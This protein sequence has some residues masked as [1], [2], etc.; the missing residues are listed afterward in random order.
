MEKDKHKTI[1][2]FRR[3]RSKPYEVI[4]FFPEIPD[5]IN[6]LYCMSYMH[7]GQHGGAD[8]IGLLGITKPASLDDTDVKELKEE[9]EQNYGYNFTVKIQATRKMHKTCRDSARR[10]GR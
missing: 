1:V 3:W 7:V 6:G 10:I 9:L 4:A 8:Y 5:D 2:I